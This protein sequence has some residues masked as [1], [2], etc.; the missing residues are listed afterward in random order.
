MDLRQLRYFIGIVDSGSLTRAARELRVAQP[1][2]SQHLKRLEEDLGLPLLLR[3]RRGI[4]PTEAG[5]RLYERG[6][7]LVAQMDDLSRELRQGEAVPRGPVSVG[8]PT[9]LGAVLS[10]PLALAVRRDYPEIRLRVVEGLSGHTLEWLRAGQLDMALVFGEGLPGM[11]MRLVAREDLRLVAAKGDS[12]L[13]EVIAGRA[14]GSVPFRAL[15]GLPLILPGRPHGVRE[16]VEDMARAQG[17]ALDVVLEMDALEHIKAL[18]AAGAG[19]TVLSERV[20][21]GG[22]VEGLECRPIVDPAIT[23]TIHLAH[24]A[25]RPLSNPARAV[26]G[27]ISASLSRLTQG[28]RW[29][30]D[31]S[32]PP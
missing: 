8:I 19:Y 6:K 14:D 15:A 17:T 13:A 24:V 10:V 1:A 25:D 2:L 12:R 5:E 16:E 26:Y 9:S 18:V 29:R 20:A 31:A 23:R 32:A 28:G 21:M 27:M 7:A 4:V 3:T 11:A 30:A 22:E